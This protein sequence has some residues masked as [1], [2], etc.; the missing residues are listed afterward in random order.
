MNLKQES[1]NTSPASDYYTKSPLQHIEI[2]CSTIWSI[3]V[4]INNLE[5]VPLCVSL[6][7][8]LQKLQSPIWLRCDI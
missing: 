1:I 7:T 6:Q 4:Y 5:T 3:I 8:K 2:K